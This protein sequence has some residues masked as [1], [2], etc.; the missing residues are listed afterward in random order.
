MK[1]ARAKAIENKMA[2][3]FKRNPFAKK[4]KATNEARERGRDASKLDQ[5]NLSLRRK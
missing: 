4:Y 1:G 5:S 2:D 3:T